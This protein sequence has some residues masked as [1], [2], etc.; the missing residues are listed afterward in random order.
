MII[1][2]GLVGKQFSKVALIKKETARTLLPRNE[3]KPI[4]G[5]EAGVLITRLK[6]LFVVGLG[7]FLFSYE[8]QIVYVVKLKTKFLCVNCIEIYQFFVVNLHRISYIGQLSI[9]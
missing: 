5:F 7:G 9:D 3:L 8:K 6:K 2:R 4:K 1:F